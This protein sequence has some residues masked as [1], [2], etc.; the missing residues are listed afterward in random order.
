DTPLLQRNKSSAVASS[1]N[2]M[3][4]PA[5]DVSTTA[6]AAPAPDVSTAA[7]AD[8]AAAAADSAAAPAPDVSTAADSAAA[9]APDVSTAAAAAE[10]MQKEDD[11]LEK[12]V[13]AAEDLAAQLAAEKAKVAQLEKE[14]DD[15]SSRASKA[16]QLHKNYMQRNRKKIKDSETATQN[17][18]DEA[19]RLRKERQTYEATVQAE[20]D[21][22]TSRYDAAQRSLKA[23]KNGH[24]DPSDKSVGQPCINAY[25]QL[26]NQATKCYTEAKRNLMV[27]PAQQSATSKFQFMD[28]SDAWVDISDDTIATGLTTLLDKT[29]TEFSYSVGG[30]N[31]KAVRA[32]D[33]WIGKCEIVQ[34]NTNPQYCT[35]RPIRVKPQ[36]GASSSASSSTTKLAL[37]NEDNKR[38][39]FGDSVVTLTPTWI[40]SLLEHYSFDDSE[41]YSK[42][43]LELA[44][45]AEIFSSFSSG[46]TY[47]QGTKHTTELYVKPLA[48]YNWLKLAESRKYTRMR[49]LLHG[50]DTKCYNGVRDDPFGMDLKFAGK[51][52]QN[53]G[54]GHYFGLSDHVSN[55]YNQELNARKKK[56][57]TAIMALVLTGES[58]EGYFYTAKKGSYGTFSLMHP[59]S[60]N[61]NN[62]LAVYEDRLLLVLG[63]IVPL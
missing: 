56:E 1:S 19:E 41:H 52:G 45:L 5:P 35:Q 14:R 42:P 12:A 29:A 51:N 10:A 9:P 30:H 33:Q 60:P 31:Y 39:L 26:I 55:C 32:Y 36:Y 61:V 46:L 22:M 6:A 38:I 18:L 13:T 23:I 43:C 24:G 20:R 54:N 62:C 48:I 15:E 49:V 16:E 25:V 50:S 11:C 53:Y 57:G 3:Q 21:A 58:L 2:G 4:S 28:A 40:N 44:Q 27:V 47:F 37:T 17:A 8:S 59:E 63:K 7:A 34:T